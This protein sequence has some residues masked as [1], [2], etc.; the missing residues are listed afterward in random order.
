MALSTAPVC[1]PDLSLANQPPLLSQLTN[2]SPEN[3]VASNSPVMP[4]LVV[5]GFLFPKAL[6]ISDEP[7]RS[8]AVRALKPSFCIRPSE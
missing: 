6:A 3:P 2:V 8:D 4:L 5:S 1:L 7:D